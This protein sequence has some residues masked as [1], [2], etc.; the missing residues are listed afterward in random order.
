MKLDNFSQFK[1]LRSISGKT[2]CEAD[3][4]WKREEASRRRGLRR[5]FEN[6]EENRRGKDKGYKY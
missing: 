6:D 1:Q 5:N 2:P 3:S 4:K